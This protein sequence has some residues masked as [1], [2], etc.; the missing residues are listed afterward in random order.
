LYGGKFTVRINGTLIDEH[1]FGSV[2]EGKYEAVVLT[3]SF[4]APTSGMYT[5]DIQSTRQ[6]AS[7]TELAHYIDNIVLAPANPTLSADGQTFSTF[8]SYTRTFDL[9]AGAAHAGGDYWLWVGY[10][11]TYPGIN[12]SGKNIPLNYDLLV[13]MCLGY[14]GIPDPSFFGTLDA[15]GNAQAKLKWKP[16]NSLLGLTIYFGYVVLSPGHGLPVVMASN[17][18]NCTVAMFD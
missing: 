4:T 14:P 6:I 17:P 11:G 8:Y 1:D 2:T 7:T 18:V 13:Q 15:S 12:L 5:L 9:T 10:S 3:G 16:D